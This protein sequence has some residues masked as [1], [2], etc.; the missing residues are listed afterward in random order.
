MERY[1][2][3]MDRKTI[4]SRCQFFPIKV[5]ASDF[6]NINKLILVLA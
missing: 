1:S 6:G 4:L 3:F 2:V 5:P